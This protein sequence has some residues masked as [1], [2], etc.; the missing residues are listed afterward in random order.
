MYEDKL[1]KA[2]L[3]IEYTQKHRTQAD[4]AREIGVSTGVVQK[5]RKRHGI[6]SL[7]RPK[8]LAGQ[9]FE[10]LTV[11][12]MA[13]NDKHGK[14][15]WVCQ[16][17]CGKR[18]TLNASSLLRKLS[19]SCGCY[20]RE[21]NNLGYK[22]ISVSHWRRTQQSAISRKL[23]F[24][25][26]PEY[27]WSVFEKQGFRCAYTGLLVEFCSNSN[28]RYLQTASIDRID[29]NKGYEPDNIQVVHK[30]INAMKGILNNEEFICFCFLISERHRRSH[31][32]C[33]KATSR[34]IMRKMGST[35]VS[36]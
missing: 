16:C 3:E 34:N 32:D 5:Y 7:Y 17:S 9:S 18:V 12:H 22:D 11:L 4:I 24:S 1:T 23:L 14:T 19:S 27:V 10:R 8:D 6:P 29:S 33:I 31:E 20:R 28:Y 15:R 30:A 26:T 36:Q 25:I 35:S 2:Y 21:L 13:E